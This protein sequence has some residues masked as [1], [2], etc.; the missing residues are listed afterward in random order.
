MG[1]REF[2][3]DSRRVFHHQR[4]HDAAN[5]AIVEA[6]GQQTVTEY[7]KE[8]TSGTLDHAVSEIA[9]E[10]L[11]DAPSVSFTAGKN[12]IQTVEMLETG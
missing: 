8:I 4:T 12:L 9:H 7:G 3:A 10:R 6:W 5:T 11:I 1:L 2:H